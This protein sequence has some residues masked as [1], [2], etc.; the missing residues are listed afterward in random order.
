MEKTWHASGATALD[1]SFTHALPPSTFGSPD[2]HWHGGSSLWNT[3]LEDRGPEFESTNA[4]PLTDNAQPHTSNNTHPLS[5][6]SNSPSTAS[7]LAIVPGVT[8]F[9]LGY[10]DFFNYS[11]AHADFPSSGLV[12]HPLPSSSTSA[13]ASPQHGAEA[14]QI[15]RTGASSPK[16]TALADRRR[17][18]NVAAAKYRQKKL[19]RIGDLEKALEEVSKE[20]DDLRLQLARRDAELEVS[21]RLLST[22]R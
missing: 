6:S 9:N 3:D 20:R 1:C 22:R 12:T 2:N 21:R 15:G 19:D 13:T 5:H 18:N 4:I 17:R 8:N 11:T 10:Q 14:A 7:S 16:D